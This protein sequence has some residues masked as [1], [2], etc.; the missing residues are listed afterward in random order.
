[1]ENKFELATRSGYRYSTPRGLITTEDVYALPLQSNNGVSLDTLAKHL[2]NEIK[3]T[4]EE[5]FVVKK[6]KT[7]ATLETKFEIVK[8]II[9]V[10]LEEREA[11]ELF[12]ENKLKK[13]KILGVIA[14]KRD[15]NLKK[16]SIADL[17]K[18]AEE[19]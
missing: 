1:M 2:H 4:E 5:S 15:S 10:K 18:M 14:E 9:K 8:H 19:L 7:N 17:E 3:K 16:R 12:I 11:R 13:E 6:T